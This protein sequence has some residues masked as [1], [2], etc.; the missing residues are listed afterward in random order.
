MVI[1]FRVPLGT[2][3]LEAVRVCN[4]EAQQKHI[5]KRVILSFT[6]MSTSLSADTK[7]GATGRNPLVQLCP[8]GPN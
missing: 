8:K 2:Y 3:V 1:D 7:G 4:R 5:Y 6:T